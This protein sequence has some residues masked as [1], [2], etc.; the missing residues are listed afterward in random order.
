MNYLDAFPDYDDE[1]YIP[2]GWLDSSCKED[3]CPS[4]TDKHRIVKIYQ[5]YK[6]PEN[7]KDF[8]RYFPRF[9]AVI[10]N[11]AYQS[12]KY[13]DQIGISNLNDL[14][15]VLHASQSFLKSLNLGRV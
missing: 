15:P 12:N 4:I 8:G 6:N 7:R 10:V 5:D 2:K 9:C 14:K 1:L 11:P 3:P 13:K